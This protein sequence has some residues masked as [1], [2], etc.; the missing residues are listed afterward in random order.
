MTKPSPQPNNVWQSVSK[1]QLWITLGNRKHAV[2]PTNTELRTTEQWNESH[3]I[4]D[5]SDTYVRMCARKRGTLVPVFV[6]TYFAA[7]MEGGAGEYPRTLLPTWR[8]CGAMVSTHVLCC[9]HGGGAGPWWVPTYFAANME[10][11]RG[12]GEYPHT[13][14]P[15]WRG[16]GVMV[17]THILC[18]QHG[19]SAGPWWVP[20][21]FAANME[22]MQGHGEYTRILCCQHGGSAGPWWVPTYFTA[23]MEGVQGHG[24]LLR[25]L[26]TGTC[27]LKVTWHMTMHTSSPI[28]PA[29]LFKY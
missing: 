24:D 19:G 3:P 25:C 21:Y 28:Q 20:A 23:N 14:L 17:S 27:T 12:H 9:Q 11:V 7:N 10:G 26:K 4:Q 2:S 29:P 18:C 15:T 13:L 16:C 8:E 1:W 22:G 6:P 5:Y